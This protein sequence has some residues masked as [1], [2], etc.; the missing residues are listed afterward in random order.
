MPS[1]PNIVQYIFDLSDEQLR[2]DINTAQ[3]TNE[4]LQGPEKANKEY[5]DWTL[6]K[7]D[8][9]NCCP[10]KTSESKY[11][12]AAL[13][14][15][16]VLETFKDSASV[17]QIE[18]TVKT[19]RRTYKQ[20]CDLQSGLN[21]MLGL[22]MA[23]SGCPVVGKLRSM[24]TF[25]IPF[26]SFGETLYRSVSAYLTKQYFVYKEGGQPDWDLD[27]LQDFYHELESLNEAF[28]RRIRDIEQNDAISNAIVMFFA[29]SI[30][31]ASSI[32]EGLEEYKEYFTGT[33]ATPPRGG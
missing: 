12:P 26:C 24:A 3:G 19:E 8:Q 7:K 16:T 33:C 25:H 11:C 27:G 5:P 32:D 10:L 23:T 2:F 30:V 14:M 1:E 21:S 17:E 15:H 6:L 18:L 22:Q 9:C 13:R 20:Q 28:S 31:V 29:A 4:H